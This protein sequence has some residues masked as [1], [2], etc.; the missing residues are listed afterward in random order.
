MTSLVQTLLLT[1]CI[2][3]QKKV[4]D[5]FKYCWFKVMSQ[6]E[7]QNSL[8]AQLLTAG[9]ANTCKSSKLQPA[10][11]SITQPFLKHFFFSPEY[12][13]NS[14]E[15]VPEIVINQIELRHQTISCSPNCFVKPSAPPPI[16]L[17]NSW[18]WRIS[19]CHETLIEC[20]H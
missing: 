17:T 1:D 16:Q 2:L 12:I 19:Y 9:L 18:E 8:K 5:F 10:N 13:N 11:K 6:W 3:P 14:K 15:H 20:S 7:K 4:G